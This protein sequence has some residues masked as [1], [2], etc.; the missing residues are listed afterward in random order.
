M[1]GHRIAMLR[2]RMGLSQTQLA[3][4]INVCASA[5]GMYEQGRREPS[6]KTLADL[7]RAF[8]VSLD[9]LITGV[10]M[11]TH[12]PGKLTGFIVVMQDG[13]VVPSASRWLDELELFRYALDSQAIRKSA[14]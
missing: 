8:G 2:K 7:S 11:K 9:Y 13:E 12:K 5:I 1:I 14:L 6:A 10:D 4:Q 3:K